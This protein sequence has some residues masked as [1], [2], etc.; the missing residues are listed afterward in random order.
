M[1]VSPDTLLRLARRATLPERPTPHA[2]GVDE[3]AYRKGQDYKTILVDLDTHRPIDLL[4]EYTA[5]AFA[6][7][8]QAHPGVEIIARDRAGTFAD[9]AAQGAPD[10]AQV[11]DLFHLMKNLREALEPILERLITA[12][13]AAADMLADAAP[14]TAPRQTPNVVETNAPSSAEAAPPTHYLPVE[15]RGHRTWNG[16]RTN[17][18][19]SVRS[20]MTRS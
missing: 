5:A 2:L 8:L 15:Y 18:G 6:A 19:L 14:A 4:P 10:A 13:Q 7:W 17:C 11:A 3:W 12:R 9:G 1:P 16:W 20:A